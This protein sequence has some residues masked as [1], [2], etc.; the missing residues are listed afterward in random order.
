[1][2]YF[3]QTIQIEVKSYCLRRVSSI[4]LR[5]RSD[6][7]QDG[8]PCDQATMRLWPSRS[9]CGHD[10]AW[11]SFRARFPRIWRW[12]SEFPESF[13]EAA[14]FLNLSLTIRWV[15]A[16]C[17]DLKVRWKRS[18][19]TGSSRLLFLAQ[20]EPRS[21]ILA[22]TCT[23]GKHPP[24]PN[25]ASFSHFLFLKLT[26]ACAEWRLLICL[27]DTN[28]KFIEVWASQGQGAMTRLAGK[29][30]Q[31]VQTRNDYAMSSRRLVSDKQVKKIDS[32]ITWM[33]K[34]RDCLGDLC[35]DKGGSIQ[36][37]RFLTIFEYSMFCF[38][39]GNLLVRL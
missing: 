19:P 20:L 26:A 1:M 3:P 9:H 33:A 39:C 25:G 32:I 24:N 16:C 4:L 27:D 38:R 36:W 14:L 7:D 18:W 8:R 35:V 31:A 15:S 30:A 2:K 37:Q 34:V 28:L 29:I 22:C 13:S 6:C 12:F 23:T 10:S 5:V 21:S 17:S 11:S